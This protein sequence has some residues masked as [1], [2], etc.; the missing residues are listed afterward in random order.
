MKKLF[1]VVG[2]FLLAC[3]IPLSGAAAGKQGFS[4]VP[5]SKHFADAVN[6]L[7]ARNII[8][9]YPDGTFKPGNSIT[10][11]Q[12]AAI[13]AKMRGLDT[14]TV[15][16][17]KF[18]DVPASHGFYKAIVKMAEEGIIGGYPDGSFKPNEPIK[19]KNMAAILV[20]AFDLPRDTNVKNPFKGEVGITNDVLVIYKLGITSGTSPT[21]FS[22]NASITRGQAAKML[23]ATEQVTMKNAVTVKAGDLG[24]DTM[25][26]FV[27]DEV[28]PGVFRAVKVKGN[29]D[30]M[31]DQVQLFPIKEGKGGIVIGG[32]AGHKFTYQKYYVHVKKEGSELRLTLE[33]T[34]ETL[35][36]L[37]SLNTKYKPVQNI[38]L[39]K[40]DGENISD[41]VTIEKNEYNFTYIK[42]EKPGDYI[43]TVRFLNGDEVRYRVTAFEMDD[44][45]LY[46]TSAVEIGPPVD[47]LDPVNPEKP[48]PGQLTTYLPEEL[49]GDDYRI[50]HVMLTMMRQKVTHYPADYLITDP[51]KDGPYGDRREV[52]FYGSH[53]GKYN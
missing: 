47:P 39:A 37:V 43:A 33:K 10:R 19:R 32:R 49:Q 7:A 25:E 27:A 14:S 15:K 40:T 34:D 24:W 3:S 31:Q 38:A 36:A 51:I 21:T 30:G 16:G 12:A 45:F 48:L 26:S 11:G 41:N 28:N 42:I 6:D 20:K 13:I 4:D 29:K 18:K 44:S 46:G 35:P 9:G 2:A 8:G 52:E 5:P 53:F 22:P 1:A 23:A 50:A 17:Q